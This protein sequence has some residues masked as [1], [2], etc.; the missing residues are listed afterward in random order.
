MWLPRI[1][2]DVVEKQLAHDVWISPPISDAS[3][4]RYFRLHSHKT[5]HTYILMELG[6]SETQLLKNNEYVWTRVHHYLDKHGIR[7]PKIL[8][9]F[10]EEGCLVLEDLGANSLQDSILQASAKG[11]RVLWN[12]LYEESL[13]IL[14]QFAALPHHAA[15][16]WSHRSFDANFFVNELDF[17]WK[18]QINSDFCDGAEFDRDRFMQDARNIAQAAC[19]TQ[20]WIFTHRD[21]HSRNI[22]VGAEKFAV[23]DF[24]DARVG[25]STYDIVSLAFDP[26]VPLDESFRKELVQKFITRLPLHVQHDIEATWV[27]MGLQ[28]IIKALGSY[29]YLSANKPEFKK[30]TGPALKILSD[31]LQLSPRY[32]YLKEEFLPQLMECHEKQTLREKKN[33]CN[34]LGRRSEHASS[35]YHQPGS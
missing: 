30:H 18:H 28:R 19:E 16:G 31:L 12:E 14:T 24:Q 1:A 8:Q 13:D 33:R 26:Y 32:S 29:A 5:H 2:K 6:L 21:F 23:I 9:I 3:S 22:M 7:V 25:P 34:D 27:D 17:F 10:H 11:D 20:H 4:R 15:D 35:P